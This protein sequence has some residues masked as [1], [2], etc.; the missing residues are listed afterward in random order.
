MAADITK[1]LNRV[2]ALAKVKHEAENTLNDHEQESYQQ[3]SKTF[4]DLRAF[5]Q[6]KYETEF[7]TRVE[8]AR[9]LLT[10]QSMQNKSDFW[11]HWY[12]IDQFKITAIDRRAHEKVR[13]HHGKIRAAIDR[14]ET[15][16]ID[17]FLDR[18]EYRRGQREYSI[19][20]LEPSRDHG[21][22]RQSHKFRVQR[23]TR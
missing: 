20:V 1:D 10:D 22:E 15:R 14:L 4:D 11:H 5:E 13:R 6:Q 12:G 23:R 8:K 21:V 16:E 18:C 2:L 3:I 9:K 7:E 17:Q 19:G